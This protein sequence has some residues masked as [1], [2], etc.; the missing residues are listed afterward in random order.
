MDNFDFSG[1]QISNLRATNTQGV[2][3]AVVNGQKMNLFLS[4]LS[5]MYSNQVR[6]ENNIV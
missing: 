5:D 6:W 2:Y 1:A 3:E 4:K